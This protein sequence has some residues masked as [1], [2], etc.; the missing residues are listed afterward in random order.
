[1]EQVGAKLGMRG[2][3]MQKKGWLGQ[4]IE[5]AR[6]EMESWPDWMKETARF[7][8]S[9][10]EEEE[11]ERRQAITEAKPSAKPDA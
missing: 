10:R 5:E 1:M 7:E 3:A 4:R 8:G 11:P 6:K 2:S 9:T